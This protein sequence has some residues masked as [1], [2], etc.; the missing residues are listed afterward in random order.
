ML[1]EA[2]MLSVRKSDFER[3]GWEVEELDEH[4]FMVRNFIPAAD[5]ETIMTEVVTYTDEE[6]L[7]HY[8]DHLRDHAERE[9]GTRDIERLNKEGKLEITWDWADKNLHLKSTRNIQERLNQQVEDILKPHTHLYYN[10]L[11]TIQRQ[12]EGAELRV[13]VDNHTDPLVAYAAIMYVNDNYNGGE[14]VFPTR[15]IELHV[16][17]GTMMMF[18]ATEGY[19]H[20]VKPPLAGPH[21]YVLPSFISMYNEQGLRRDGTRDGMKSAY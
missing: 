6:W 2:E 8:M 10:G 9:H 13:H 7:G 5:L 20:G 1:T 3:E 14:L 11:G 15:G 19:P 21:R 16:P 12:Y 18:A 4:I 17:A